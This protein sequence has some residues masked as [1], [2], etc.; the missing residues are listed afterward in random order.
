[1]YTRSVYEASGGGAGSGGD[2]LVQAAER[3]TAR[4]AWVKVRI[5]LSQKEAIVRFVY[6]YDDNASA[7]V[8]LMHDVIGDDP[9]NFLIYN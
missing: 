4:V 6:A 8:P 1:M 5:G 2:A 9:M 3:G 7:W